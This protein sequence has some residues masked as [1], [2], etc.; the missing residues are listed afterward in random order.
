MSNESE[1][2][3]SNIHSN[4]MDPYSR[5][6]PDVDHA[7]K[8]M[9]DMHLTTI[10]PEEKQRLP[11]GRDTAPAYKDEENFAVI[12]EVFHQLHCLVR[13]PLEDTGMM[14]PGLTMIQDSIRK[15]FFAGT[16]NE[17]K[18][19]FESAGGHADHCFSYL[20]QTLICHADVGV[21]TLTWRDKPPVFTADFNVTKQC[22]NYDAILDWAKTR[23]SKFHVPE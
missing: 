20:A 16:N 22:R 7:W 6:N 11:G 8:K 9:I 14:S 23:H 13:M 17:T 1:K 15:G 2:F 5:D 10:T 19:G 21:M 18:T 12:L 4:V 3:A